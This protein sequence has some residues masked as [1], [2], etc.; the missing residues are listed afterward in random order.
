LRDG[1][2]GKALITAGAK[3]PAWQSL[4]RSYRLE[5]AFAF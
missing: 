4:W 1:L 5:T 3:V 2:A